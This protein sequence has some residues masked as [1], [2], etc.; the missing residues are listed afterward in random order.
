MSLMS[1]S[2]GV[3]VPAGQ[4]ARAVADS[5]GAHEDA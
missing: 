4:E 2:W 1:G 3:F 5:G